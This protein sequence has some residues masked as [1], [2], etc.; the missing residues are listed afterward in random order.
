MTEFSFLVPGLGLGLG[1]ECIWAREQCTV[2][3]TR[4]RPC[5][6]NKI[7]DHNGNKL[8]QLYCVILDKEVVTIMYCYFL[9]QI[10]STQITP[11][12]FSE[13][14]H[15]AMAK[16]SEMWLNFTKLDPYIIYDPHCERF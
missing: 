2:E 10:N 16:H 6:V 15:R 12:T 7:K 4:E 9:C 14:T 1:L 13:T 5:D 3:R 11:A 8:M